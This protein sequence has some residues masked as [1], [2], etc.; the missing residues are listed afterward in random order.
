MAPGEAL[1]PVEAGADQEASSLEEDSDDEEAIA[2]EAGLAPGDAATP[3][4]DETPVEA[5]ANEQAWARVEGL[6]DEEEE[7][8]AEELARG[9]GAAR[10]EDMVS[11]HTIANGDDRAPLETVTGKEETEPE[12][13][14]VPG[15]GDIAFEDETS[16]EAVAD[17]QAWAPVE[18]LMGA[19]EEA[20]AGGPAPG[21]GAIPGDD[22]MPVEAIA[23]EDAWEPVEDSR[24]EE[25]AVA[26]EAGLAPQDGA[27]PDEG[28]VSSDTIANEQAW[29]PVEDSGAEEE[30]APDARFA[31]G[32]GAARDGDLV[33]G[34]ALA[35]DDAWVPGAD[36][37]GKKE[38]EP[39][40]GLAPEEDA[41]LAE[42]IAPG[43]DVAAEW[44]VPGKY[45]VP[46]ERLIP[47]APWE[48]TPPAGQAA[49]GEETVPAAQA[50]TTWY[51]NAPLLAGDDAPYL[52]PGDHELA[53]SEV[54]R[55]EERNL[56]DA[57]DLAPFPA[58]DEIDEVLA[59]ED[60]LWALHEQER[61]AREGGGV[62]AADARIA[63]TS[64]IEAGTALLVSQVEPY[65]DVPG[66]TRAD[67]DEG[68]SFARVDETE[69]TDV[70]GRAEAEES[71]L[72][73]GTVADDNA[74]RFPDQASEQTSGQ[75]GGYQEKAV[76][77]ADVSDA[78]EAAAREGRE[79][80]NPQSVPASYLHLQPALDVTAVDLDPD[81]IEAAISLED[82][83]DIPVPEQV[84]VGAGHWKHSLI[85]LVLLVTLGGQALWFNL[86]LVSDRDDVRPWLER[87]CPILGCRVPDYVEPG[88]LESGSLVIRSHPDVAGALMVDAILRNQARFRQRFPSLDLRF[89]DL[90]G[91]TLAQR[92][93]IPG[94]YLRGEMTG[95]KYIPSRT[96][97]RLAFEIVDPGRD[98]VGYSLSIVEP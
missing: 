22:M 88:S 65:P 39:E 8:R 87:G 10:G 40:A 26:P 70:R 38:A 79:T 31:P 97:V 15:Y 4:E 94:E 95:R 52:S 54:T 82:Q 37:A 47:A 59:Q 81:A 51:D 50:E 48:A 86:D 2:P 35:N 67:V 61:R 74:D 91:Q 98:A 92:V 12:V 56:A 96:E 55:G 13:G 30:V 80:G 89:L 36:I 84:P 77:G 1:N 85:A 57:T 46:G 90:N 41:A 7:A 28:M 5:I 75:P 76:A 24:R 64:G 3:F 32:D 43:D 62:E 69:D 78:A 73:A 72:P 42:V 71:P 14:P 21:Q 83:I 63:D 53:S 25:E 20:P 93:F 66:R 11:S 44:E 58:V 23:N 49:P 29:A 34:E 19:E 27:A 68:D 60:A 33:S 17:E 16:V 6:R 9:D 18:D 45:P